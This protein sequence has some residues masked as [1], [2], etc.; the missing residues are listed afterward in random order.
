[1]STTKKNLYQNQYSH[2]KHI[3]KIHHLFIV[4]ILL[5]LLSLITPND[6]ETK[7]NFVV[8]NKYTCPKNRGEF[9][10]KNE[11]VCIKI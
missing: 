6:E 3:I 11:C 7:D 8:C 1:M 5:S 4:F 10:D 2:H 9:N